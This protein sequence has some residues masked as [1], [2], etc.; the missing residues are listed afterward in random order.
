MSDSP[1]RIMVSRHS[2]FYSP[3]IATI[4]AGFL[5]DEGLEATYAVLPPGGRSHPLLMRGE[6]DV[7]QSAPGSNWG[8]MERGET[9]L[10]VH[11]ALINRRDGFFLASRGP[12]PDFQWSQLQ[13]A[14]LLADHG[15]QPLL[16]LQY[17]AHVQG[18]EWGKID[19]I[20]A[21]GVEEIETAFRSGRGDY[22]HLQ[23]PAPQQLQHEGLA[24]VAASVGEAMPQVAF[25]TL[26]ATREFLATEQ[27]GAFKRAY[28]RSR[29]WVR[30][31]P[32]KEVADK[33]AS[34]FEGVDPAALTATIARYQNV[35]CW[36]GDL[37]IARDLYEQALNVFLHGNAIAHRHPYEG[38]VVSS[39]M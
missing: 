3:L 8:P 39:V 9:D 19:V 20:D 1:L 26:M 27:A 10:P 23:G 17:A 28:R 34:F 14:T 30:Q 21:G 31:A 32:P 2:T 13:G 5:A 38:V 6:V 29:E 37:N 36:D 12:E 4:A 7:M 22:V 24:Y 16:M 15:R 35:G 18:V 33:E 11:F 25:S